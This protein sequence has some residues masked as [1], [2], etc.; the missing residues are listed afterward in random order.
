MKRREFLCTAG[1]LLVMWPVLAAAQSKKL[2]LIGVLGGAVPDDAEVARNLAAFRKG[3]AETGYVEGQ[4]VQIEYRWAAGRYER[5]PDLAA[6]LVALNVDVIVNEGGAT[7]VLAAA[8]ATRTIPIVFHTSTDPVADGLIA[9]LA[10]PGGNL[11]G[12]SVLMVQLVPKL[13]Q[14]VIEVVPNVKNVA[15]LIN[16]DNMSAEGVR[17]ELVD[18]AQNKASFRILAASNDDQI[19]AAF[20]SLG[21]EPADALLVGSDTFFTTRRDR[22]IALAAKAAV[23]A[24]YPQAFWTR[25][26]GL[27]SYGPSLQAA[28]RLKGQ[29]VGKILDGKKPADLPVQEP[30]TLEL[31]IN[32]KTAK[33]LGLELPLILQQRADEVI[34]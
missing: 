21:K 20:A 19:D 13:F 2:P 25:A 9:S 31:V 33:A 8:K 10:R 16:P 18:V 6:E 23:P 27:I 4:N 29:Y 3:L 5:L 22:I 14:F 26:G 1:G 28:Y 32:L 7:S 11:T 15:L 30:T 17:R 12:V 24:V 34:E